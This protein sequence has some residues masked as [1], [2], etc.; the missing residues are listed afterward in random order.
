MYNPG[1][2]SCPNTAFPAPGNLCLHYSHIRDRDTS[3]PGISFLRDLSISGRCRSESCVSISPIRGSN[4]T[5]LHNYTSCINVGRCKI[6]IHTYPQLQENY[7]GV[8]TSRLWN[9]S[10]LLFLANTKQEQALPGQ[11]WSHEGF[12]LYPKIVKNS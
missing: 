9:Y 1:A 8:E 7:T 5:T 4:I 3:K 6:Y 2:I 10:F 11:V 12:N